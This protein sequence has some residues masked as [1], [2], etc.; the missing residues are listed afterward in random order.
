MDLL[1]F[2]TKTVMARAEVSLRQLN[3]WDRLGI[4]SPSI[5]PAQGSGSRRRYSAEDM[6]LLLLARTLRDAQVPLQS[7][8]DALSAVRAQGI[9]LH[10]D[11]DTLLLCAGDRVAYLGSDRRRIHDESGR[12]PAVFVLNVGRLAAQA[13][14]LTAET[15]LPAVEVVE[16]AGQAIQVVVTPRKQGYE[17]R[18]NAHPE[19]TG[20]GSTAKEAIDALK[21]SVEGPRAAS[22]PHRHP[23]RRPRKVGPAPPTGASAWGDT[24]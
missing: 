1:G 7:V 24:W 5:Q 11:P 18:C 10:C 16:V 13:A 17:A 12:A 2:D 19:S 8:R 3:H 6:F 20:T 22:P 23:R 14:E 9:G 4:V 15:T 21:R